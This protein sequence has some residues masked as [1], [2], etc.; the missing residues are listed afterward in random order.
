MTKKAK[1]ALTNLIKDALLARGE[2]LFAYIHGSFLSL[3]DFRDIDVALFVNPREVNSRQAFDYSFRLS[4]E[5]SHLAAQ[6]IDIQIM[7]YAPLGFRHSVFKNGR[8]LFSRDE[9]LRTDL[10][11][12]AA[13]EYIAFYE[14]SLQYIQD[15]AL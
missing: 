5:L 9:T 15:L 3:S 14:L 8:L 4:V 1:D 7:N 13:L 2:I 6:E 10:L 11:E 12:G